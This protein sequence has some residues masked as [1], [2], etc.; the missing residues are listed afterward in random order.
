MSVGF[1]FSFGDFVQGISL[2]IGL[3]QALD[4]VKGARAEIRMLQTELN[5]LRSALEAIK[6]CNL[7]KTDLY[8]DTAMKAVEDSLEA[9][10][11]FGKKVAKYIELDEAHN[12]RKTWRKVKWALVRREDVDELRTQVG[13][14][15]TALNLLLSAIH[16]SRTAVADTKSTAQLMEQSRIIAEIHK[17]LERSDSEY[18]QFL[19]K[20]ESL[21]ASLVSAPPY[22]VPKP[23]FEVRPLRLIGAP[24]IAMDHFVERPEVMASIELAFSSFSDTLQKIVVLQG[25]LLYKTVLGVRMPLTF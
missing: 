23:T 24:V 15:V 18:I 7:Q 17:H 20:I 25:E 4:D 11:K 22:P 19:Q 1:G 16:L 14:Q 13:A 9:I 10:G 12:V 6:Q 2:I 8:F 5:V 21:V 3:V